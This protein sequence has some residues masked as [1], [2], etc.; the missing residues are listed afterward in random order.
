[1]C[2]LPALMSQE[3]D[4]LTAPK[5]LLL[6][7]HLRNNTGSTWRACKIRAL[8]FPAPETGFIQSSLFSFLQF[9]LA[10]P[11]PCCLFPLNELLTPS[12]SPF[13]SSLV[14]IPYT[15]TVPRLF[16]LQHRTCLCAVLRAPPSPGHSLV[17]S[18]TGA[19]SHG[20][21]PIQVCLSSSFGLILPTPI[22]ITSWADTAVLLLPSNGLPFSIASY[23]FMLIAH[24]HFPPASHC[25]VRRRLSSSSEILPLPKTI[26]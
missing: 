6:S 25:L 12:L 13:S 18:I 20:I 8:V 11:K 22:E 4:E 26:L 24:P 14:H 5:P 16:C 3:N 15:L 7:H 17:Q 2:A 10:P 9:S 21:N 19:L 1:M 23:L